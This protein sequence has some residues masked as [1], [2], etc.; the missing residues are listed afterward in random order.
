M[1][2]AY[3]RKEFGMEKLDAQIV[4]WMDRYR[5]KADTW[6]LPPKPA[7]YLRLVPEEKVY[8]YKAGPEGPDRV[9]NVV[10]AGRPHES[11]SKRVHDI[12][13]P[14]AV[15]KKNNVYLTRTYHIERTGPIDLMTRVSSVGEYFKIVKGTASID[16][17]EGYTSSLTDTRIYDEDGDCGYTVSKGEAITYTQVFD[18]NGKPRTP[19]NNVSPS[20][21]KDMD[22][23]FFLRR[24]IDPQ[25]RDDTY[26]PIE[27][28]GDIDPAFFGVND[29]ANLAYA[30]IASGFP[31]QVA[32]K[33]L[34]VDLN[35]GMRLI[36][37]LAQLPLTTGA[38]A[39]DTDANRLGA[40][41]T[42]AGAAASAATAG[43][44][45]AKDAARDA[46]IAA[47]TT[48]PE[49]AGQ[50]SWVA[51]TAIAAAPA[52]YPAGKVG[53]IVEAFVAAVEQV[54]TTLGSMMGSSGNIFLDA[55]NALPVDGYGDATPA[56][57]LYENLLNFRAIPVYYAAR[58]E[59]LA[60]RSA[61]EEAAPGLATAFGYLLGALKSEQ[62]GRDAKFTADQLAQ[63]AAVR[64]AA[65]GAVNRAKYDTLRST[66]L[67][68][69]EFSKAGSIA[70]LKQYIGELDAAVVAAPAK[71]PAAAAGVQ[72]R[73]RQRAFVATTL[74]VHENNKSVT[75]GDAR[76]AGFA[77]ASRFDITKARDA[78]ETVTG[79][80]GSTKAVELVGMRLED[81]PLI[82]GLM[83]AQA[84]GETL[85]SASESSSHHLTSHYD[86]VD[87]PLESFYE[88]E[89]IG[90][91][92]H[93]RSGGRAGQASLRA[94]I[95][96]NRVWV[97]AAGAQLKF[98][99]VNTRFGTLARNLDLLARSTI[100][101]LAKLVTA[102]YY[103][104]PWLLETLTGF[105]AS[106]I[107]APC[108]ILGFRVGLYDMALGIKCKAGGETG[109][110]YFGHSDF[111]LADDATIKI[112][113][114]NYTH[115]G[116]SVIHKPENVFIAY[117]IFPNK[118][119]GGMGVSPYRE[120]NQFVPEDQ[121]FLADIFYIMVPYVETSFPK[122]MSMAGRF[123]T[124]MDAGMLDEEDP[125]NRA[126]HYSTAPYYNRFWGWYS[127]QEIA[128]ELDEPM[129]R[130]NNPGVNT[131]VWQGAQ[132]T[133][134][135]D[136]KKFDCDIIRNKSP[137]YVFFGVVSLVV[138]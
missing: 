99:A 27:Y 10:G 15:F 65:G 94:G 19:S 13:E 116:K 118:C 51:L 83:G 125:A 123:Y 84:A 54:A 74:A 105:E 12:V 129:Y 16:Y 102:L 81:I 104:S 53:T 122:V 132:G 89:P 35:V 63:L 4:E 68:R 6:V 57:V 82:R 31:D 17:R 115:Y 14:F 136:S 55:A 98:Q 5:A 90:M 126:L 56:R 37:R 133:Y 137:W 120:K 41:K 93:D 91:M 58:D 44:Q 49:L 73:G 48:V 67:T 107:P 39:L 21:A 20:D 69:F 42:A 111:M 76:A 66:L 113:Y 112:H 11:N 38:E 40:A 28:L 30:A 8:Y 2:D 96:S 29:A 33:K 106:N 135:R 52:D 114:G 1:T 32:R 43:N 124:Y 134:N 97:P 130:M 119:L 18:E 9:N 78:Y 45:G 64:V 46:A 22:G 36:N 92:A 86:D 47:T 110:T 131:N 79:P 103:G 7:M 23:V 77:L 25:T 62:E 128:V 117:D 72:V 75:S 138:F 121:Q 101:P 80:D 59:A 24:I 50:T 88:S 60:G 71:L 70:E 108:G 109:Y 100:D 127:E 85:G 87:A 34:V 61:E 3:R 26:V 95:E